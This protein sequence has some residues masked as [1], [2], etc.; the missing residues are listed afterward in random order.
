MIGA[1]LARDAALLLPLALAAASGHAAEPAPRVLVAAGATWRYFVGVEDPST[2]LSRW[3]EPGFDDGAWPEGPSGFGYGDGDDATSLEDS[4]RGRALTAYVRTTFAVD[5]PRRVRALVLR[6]AYD[7]GFVAY[8]NGREVARAGV[9]G[10]PP[11]RTARARDHEAGPP[12][13]LV[14]PGAPALLVDGEN[15]LAIEVHDSSLSSSDLSLVPE[16]LA[17]AV[18][19]PP[20][21]PEVGDETG[22]SAA[23]VVEVTPPGRAPLGTTTSRRTA[24]RTTMAFRSASNYFQA[25]AGSPATGV[26]A[27]LL[28]QE[29]RVQPRAIPDLAL[30]LRVEGE[31]ISTL[32]SPFGL[33]AR[34]EGA[35]GRH[36]LQLDLDGRW[37][38]PAFV[39]AGEL[40]TS[41]TSASTLTWTCRANDFVEVSSW[42][43]RAREQ[44]TIDPRRNNREWTW[45]AGVRLLRGHSAFSPELGL[46]RTDREANAPAFEYAQ[47]RVVLRLRSA[48]TRR[49]HVT[50]L[51]RWADREYTHVER[52]DRRRLARV[53]VSWQA[54]SLASVS[55]FASAHDGDSSLPG[56]SFE[57]YQAWLGVTL[58]H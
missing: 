37:N 47:D 50:G 13:D 4:M 6:I 14:L 30:T 42:V 29:V 26:H 25:V 53:L 21:R 28:R 56:R 44:V 24:W 10:R 31:R 41:D 33:G 55:G 51:L 5:R 2:P 18:E 58:T 22:H 35:L 7:D 49:I 32:G 23:D 16:L 45:G 40:A 54:S 12:E 20:D 39:L 46:E 17:L 8:L 27:L 19:P 15:V 34:V 11:A 9:D 48:L 36:R 3:A 57:D 1:R 52:D 43:A 38:R